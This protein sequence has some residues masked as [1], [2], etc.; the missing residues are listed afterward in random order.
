[1][2]PSLPDSYERLFHDVAYPQFMLIF[3]E[4]PAAARALAAR[5]L[6]RAI[7]VIYA[8][9]TER[10][11]HYFHAS[12]SRQFDAVIHV[13]ATTAVRPLE[14]VAPFEPEEAETFPSGV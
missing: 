8:P 4:A 10:L 13:D 7:G 11:S 9:R 3:E 12:L 5:R 6:E 2:N 1:V 14:A